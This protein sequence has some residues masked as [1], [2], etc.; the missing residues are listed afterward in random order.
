MDLTLNG[1]F[2]W[3]RP[4]EEKT[5][6]FNHSEVGKRRTWISK[7][8]FLAMAL[9][10]TFSGMLS[11]ISSSAQ[12]KTTTEDVTK[13]TN[14]QGTTNG[15][16]SAAADECPPII[17]MIN[18]GFEEPPDN[19]NNS[20]FY[21]E[22]D[23]PGWLTTASDSTIE[24]WNFKKG[25]P[26][27]SKSF[28]APPEGDR[29]AEL[30]ANVAGM[31]YQDVQVV[32]GQLLYWRLSH[33]GRTGV[34]TMQ[35][36][37]GAATA[38]PTDTPVVQQ[39]SDGNK[40]WGT[41]RGTYQVP[42]GQTVTRFG[43]E[44][45]K[46]ANGV[47][48][49]GNFLD[50]IFLGTEP[51]VTAEKTVSPEGPVHTGD[52]LTYNVLVKNKGGD[53]A[54]SSVFEDAIPAGTVYV[55]GSL[56]ITQGPGAGSLTD[57]QDS[58]AG[59]FDSANNKVV[60]NLGDLENTN[61]LPDGVTV[62][63]K[64]KPLTESAGKTVSNQATVNYTNLLTSPNQ[65]KTT[66]S[67]NVDTPILYRDPQLQSEKS[68]TIEHK[69]DGNTD[70]EHPEVGDTLRYTI[71]TQNTVAD[72]QV[73][74]NLTI[75]D[76][77][78]KGLAYVPDSLSVDGTSV[79]DAQDEDAG[80]S[81]DGTVTGHFGDVTDK[82]V[83]K[84]EFLVTVQPGQA[85]QDIE[86][87]A[88]VGGDNTPPNNP[89]T[90]VK[91]YPREPKLESH[92]EVKN[93]TSGDPDKTS[94]GDTLE[95]TISSRNTISDGVVTN[96]TISD[97][98]PDGLE[99][100]AGSLKVDGT[101]VTDAQDNDAGDVTDGKVTGRLGDVTDT[102]THTVT[103]QAKVKAGQVNK[104]IQNTATVGGDNT[105]PDNPS[106]VV[107]VNPKDPQL[108]SEK[109][110]TIEQ[111]A[112]GN[113]DTEHP[114]VGDTLRYTIQTKNTVSDSLVNN[115]VISDDIPD[116]LAYVPGSLTVDGTAVTDDTDTDAGESANGKV[117]GRFGDVL[118]TDT[119]K[120]EFLVTVQPGQ[121]GHDIENTATVGGDNTPPDQPNTVVQ[122]YPRDPKLE[123]K[124]EMRNLTTGN[125]NQI[126]V[127]DILE[128]TIS[129]RNTVSEGVVNNFTIS[130]NLPDGLEYVA[131]S[132]TVD[133][134]PATDVA[135]DDAGEFVNGKVMGRFGDV[136][137]TDV[138]TVTF[139]VK[140]KAGQVDKNIQNTA[141]VGG[142]NTPPDNPSL[143]IHVDPI[144]P[145]LQ[146]EK[147]FTIEQK[148]DGNTDTEHPEVGDTLHYT[149]QTKNTVENSLV[150][151]LVISDTIPDG[152][153]YVPGSLTVDGQA[154]TDGADDDVGD[155]ID[156]TVTGRFG[157][158]LDTD[159]HK[160]EFLVTVQS[161]QAGH[162]IE[163]T[164]TVGGD[165]TPP[166]HPNTV[167]K[168]Y[169]RIPNIESTKEVKNL[170]R[171]T[172]NTFVGDTVEYTISSRNTVS[173]GVV[174][175]WVISDDLPTGLE[176]TPG[177]LTVD[178]KAVTDAT[179]SDAG[180]F[181]NGTVT[182][183]LGDVTDTDMHTVTFRATVTAENREGG[184]IQNTAT[185]TG[186]NIPPD[187]P[188]TTIHVDPKNPKLQS[189]KTVAVE[190]KA[191]GNLDTEHPEIGDTLRY[192]IQT[193]NTVEDSQV[194]KNL[195]I[196][197]VI[198]DDL[199]YVPGSLTVD[200]KA[201]T[202]A[203]D[204]DAGD[205]TD[206]GVVTGHLGDVADTD[207]H[208]IT[209]LVKVKI[210]DKGKDIPNTATVGGDNTPPD[211]PSVNVHIDP[212]PPK[213]Q[214][215]KTVTI[216]EK[217]PG[218]MD[219]DHPEPGDTLQYTIQTKNTVVNS[220]V[221]NLIIHD[222]L[223][224]GLDYVAG[225]LK[226][227]GKQVTDARDSD[228][229]YF[230]D[231]VAE[232]QFG[233]ILDND[234]H[235][236]TFQAKVKVD[237]ESKDIQ[238]TATVGGDNTPPDNPSV[239]IHLDPKDPKLQSEKSV[240][241]EKK[242]AG[243]MD[244]DHPEPGDTVRYTIQTKNTVT[245]SLVKNLVIHDKLPAGLDYVAGSL[246]VDSKDV[247]D[248]QDND[249]G[250]FVD[251]AVEG[252][253]GDIRDTDVHTVT[254]EAQIKI[255]GESEDIQN[256]ATVGGDNTPPDDPSTTI[257]IDP[258]DPK[259]QSEKTVA[260]EKK[261]PGNTDSKH[262]EPGDTVQYTVQTKN[263]V[264]NSLVKN[265]VIHDKLPAG[266]DYVAGS[267]K[268]DGKQ[269][270]DAKDNDAGHFVDGAVEGQFGD[271]GDTDVHT[272]TFQAKIKIDGESED[273]KNTAT[274]GGD[275]TPPG[276]P[277]VDIHIDPKVPKLQSE[278]TSVIEHKGNGNTDSKHAEVGDTLLYTIQIK[279]TVMNSLVKALTVSD[280]L[281]AG[282]NYV[283]GSLKVDGKQV[284]DAKDNDAGHFVDGAVEG[285][286]GDVEDTDMH[287]VT[288]QATIASGQEGKTI[289][290][291]AK[292]N[293]P[294]IDKPPVPR[295]EVPVDPKHPEP[296]LPS[297]GDMN[298]MPM[299]MVGIAFLLVG[300]LGYTLVRRRKREH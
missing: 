142:D 135:G 112:D 202:D 188:S 126:F 262:P 225:S 81:T 208:T 84:L 244:A 99:Y 66:T 224:A 259:L 105:P 238:N 195:V 155:S 53:I 183:H 122:V 63:F 38:N 111:K 203:A 299:V 64:V 197:D 82:N 274:V 49:T 265:L 242:A 72:S 251:G 125:S 15:R 123:S 281:P 236:I 121:A 171:D 245:N 147:S 62:Q 254:F 104:D 134:K 207:T 173:E 24:I 239:T 148:A 215:E 98:I 35:L 16:A 127:G 181:T 263:T 21:K 266:L 40:A 248:A 138:H 159:T 109:S 222:Q 167:V 154:V 33:M 232:G 73:V 6:Q 17:A 50:N 209:F 235:T 18:G 261:A 110:F 287:T 298:D 219:A 191:P 108:Q 288:F 8:F 269:V 128:Y 30:N 69:A 175:N 27:L 231:G 107:H 246:K 278:K 93:L 275:N 37:I 146:S 144:P 221:R 137:D 289:I 283:A 250:H 169:P 170:T 26:S 85:G 277:S 210:D 117:T 156:G 14:T 258:K 217:A 226:V 286:F 199:D 145:Q 264:T 100:V 130:D 260:I 139:Q 276:D 94:V 292:I 282:L 86:N 70:T 25:N 290:N 46:T 229:G 43:F 95:Y 296:P 216:A 2:I 58:D 176:Y 44:A 89:N 152:L 114:E 243:N 59:R 214:S 271:I 31:L 227:D 150:N 52:E 160:I 291:I 163:N 75:S 168:V 92:K 1:V 48:S 22:S 166:D 189:E 9:L 20:I 213:L 140:V 83:H 273:I 294:S 77:I 5:L 12:A 206:D 234:T 57:A 143:I 80:D 186:D 158:V 132:L 115:L 174:N 90:V 71:Q 177:S 34:D 284:T 280:P 249:A 65:I 182:G 74:K 179:D 180:D 267:L 41:Y 297:T 120:I 23:V 96:F 256:T 157:D 45:V 257:H 192:T 223:P 165:N 220:L 149:I 19:S 293:T 270:T 60:V 79:T 102:N 39:M 300:M 193:K 141:T 51:C 211:H 68:F 3:L 218:N 13:S 36:R 7:V 279:N 124:K 272:I 29:Y 153:A 129:S 240:A 91:V 255:T 97:T 133:G 103:F 87:T 185:I 11:P 116:G 285:Q 164:A 187:N 233:N 78:P 212:N 230:V 184:D 161:G 198:S 268:V 106:V 162:D 205:V 194:I 4:K 42:A 200:G 237:G 228:A 201:V 204:D 61:E 47:N 88:T 56:R 76:A 196:S 247:T 32:P 151:N 101:A 118:D 67:N 241:I 136:T 295:N 10:I 178:G 119:H 113:M 28:P 131:D 190:Q 252:Q 172:G 54:A 55:P 253:F